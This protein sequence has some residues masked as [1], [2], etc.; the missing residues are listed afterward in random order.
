MQT[1]E[2]PIDQVSAGRSPR[3]PDL[4][5]WVKGGV[6]GMSA[7]VIA[8]AAWA[9]DITGTVAEIGARNVAQERERAADRARVD[10]Q[11]AR[12]DERIRDILERQ[13]QRGDRLTK[14]EV[15][16][17]LKDELQRALLLRLDRLESKLDDLTKAVAGGIAPK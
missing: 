10:E 5:R 6:G 2:L 3:Q 14:L 16:E 11:Q 15:R 4:A 13:E 1:S 12:T 9:H 17:E 8:A 7:V